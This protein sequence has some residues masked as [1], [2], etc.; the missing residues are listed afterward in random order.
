MRPRK[1]SEERTT[2]RLG[3]LVVPV[4]IITET[5]RNSR[6]SVTQQAVIIRIP[7]GISGAQ[8]KEAVA[9]MIDW[10]RETYAKK[11]AAFEHFRSVDRSGDHYRFELRG[12]TYDLRVAEHDAKHHRIRPDGPNQ[13]LLHLSPGDPRAHNG[14]IIP[15]LL[16]KHF[17]QLEL[18]RVS[19]RVDAL[20]DE[21][22]G[23]DINN[24]KLSDTYSRWGSCSSKSN[25]NLATRLILAPDEVLDAVII[26]ELAHLVEANHSPRFW[27]EVARALPDY[28][29]YDRWLKE[30]GKELVFL[31]TLVK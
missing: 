27:A 14:K 7:Y 11:P 30:H 4:W 2:L 21:H 6:A 25:I 18:A 28:R 15:K 17:G 16:A 31:P 29:D 19:R 23:K 5:R 13:L 22:F 26:H 1:I 8:Q 9:T 20:N 12:Q 24:I 3:D 10:V